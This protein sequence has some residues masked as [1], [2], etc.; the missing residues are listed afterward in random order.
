MDTAFDAH[1][2]AKH[3]HTRVE[4]DLRFERAAYRV[5]QVDARPAGLRRFASYRDH[6]TFRAQAALLWRLAL[7]EHKMACFGRVGFRQRFRL[8]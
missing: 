6:G 7:E 2:F 8:L 3:Q 4:R 1:I 5:D